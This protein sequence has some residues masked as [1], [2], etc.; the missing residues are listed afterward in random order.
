VPVLVVISKPETSPLVT[1]VKPDIDV[2]AAPVGSVMVR[3]ISG[4][5]PLE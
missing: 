3:I 5:V 4:V 1:Y 2:T